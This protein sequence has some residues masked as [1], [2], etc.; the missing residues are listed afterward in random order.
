MN[1]YNRKFFLPIS[2]VRLSNGNIILN[3][4]WESSI[5]ESLNESKINLLSIHDLSYNCPEFSEYNVIDSK[6]DVWCI[7]WCLYELCTLIDPKA[8]LF[9]AH[10]NWPQVSLPSNVSDRLN[11]LFLQMTHLNP[12]FRPSVSEILANNEAL[13]CTNEFQFGDCL[14]RRFKIGEEIEQNESW[15]IIDLKESNRKLVFI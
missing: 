2:F 1:F 15:N 9:N 5:V 6:Y 11:D 14:M 4:D 13:F 10:L 8:V 12:D 3:V 7:G